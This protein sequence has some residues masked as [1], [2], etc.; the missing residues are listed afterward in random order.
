M[1][2]Q[3]WRDSQH[4]VGLGQPPFVDLDDRHDLRSPFFDVSPM[5]TL[6][7]VVMRHGDNVVRE[8]N[9]RH[10]HCPVAIMT[11]QTEKEPEGPMIAPKREGWCWLTLCH[12]DRQC[13]T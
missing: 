1:F 6:V 3:K 9:G 12:L 2:G 7:V 8:S 13:A 5:L 11:Y 4:N 10:V